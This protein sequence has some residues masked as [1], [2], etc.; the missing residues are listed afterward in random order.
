MDTDK[1]QT[2]MKVLEYNS[3]SK[4]AEALGYT[5][6]AIS[7]SIYALEKSLGFKILNREGGNVSLTTSGK[8]ILPYIKNVLSAQ[9][10]LEQATYSLSQVTLGNL[11]IATIPSLAIKWF[12]VLFQEYSEYYSQ[13]NITLSHGNYEQ[14]ESSILAG[15]VD[16]GFL[17]IALSSPLHH[18]VI[19]TECLYAIFP[20]DHPLLKKD[21]LSL[22]DLKDEPFIMPGEGDKYQV[23]SLIEKYR[24]PMNIRYT[25]SDDDITVALVAQGLG[26]SILPELSYKDYLNFNIV[27]RTLKE[28]PVREISI[29][30]RDET[31]ISPIGKDFINFA[32]NFFQDVES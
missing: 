3:F 12:P 5:Q 28:N 16:C 31:S 24:C 21:S 4:A 1:Y 17:P 23:G 9:N 30:Y 11:Y 29:A 19:T 15:D 26:I 22:K 14:V 7:H 20:P 10:A 6:S 27:P 25:I 2:L 13:I 18:Q 32:V 8:T